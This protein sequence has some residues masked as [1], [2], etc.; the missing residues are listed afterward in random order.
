M[1]TNGTGGSGR[2][3]TATRTPQAPG[4]QQRPTALTLEVADKRRLPCSRMRLSFRYR[5]R[6]TKQVVTTRLREARQAAGLTQ[7]QV[8]DRLG[9]P[10]P[11][12]A[13]WESGTQL[14]RVDA[15]L[16]VAAAVD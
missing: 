3:A 12:V 7:Q 15:A 14:P 2:R 10:R 6:Y 13:R 4:M 8:A 1:A 9:V 5:I 16:R 11:N